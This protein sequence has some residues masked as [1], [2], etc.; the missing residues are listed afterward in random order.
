[1]SDELPPVVRIACPECETETTVDRSKARES[2]HRHDEM[3]HDGDQT[4]GLKV[5]TED[6]FEILPHPDDVAEGLA[7]EDD[8]DTD[9]GAE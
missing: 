4:A 8:S 5:Q 7:D 2:L 1:M 9:G 3:R 6:G